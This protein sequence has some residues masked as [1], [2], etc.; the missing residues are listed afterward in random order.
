[1]RFSEPRH[2][3]SRAFNVRIVFGVNSE[4]EILTKGFPVKMLLTAFVS[5]LSLSATAQAAV[6]QVDC[7]GADAQITANLIV[8][9]RNVTGF[10]AAA[11]A[12]VEAFQADANGSYIFYKAGEYY[13][14]FDL[15]IIE[16]WGL[17]GDQSVGYKSYTD[18]NGK[19]IQTVLVNKKAIQAQCMIAKQ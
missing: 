10:V 6:M 18:K 9:G 2:L 5:L 13:T 4:L 12:G 11:G 16:F 15:E 3:L 1:M 14:D 19:F 7:V 8:E 17:S